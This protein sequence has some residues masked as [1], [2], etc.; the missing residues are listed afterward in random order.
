MQGFLYDNDE[1]NPADIEDIPVYDIGDNKVA[2]LLLPDIDAKVYIATRGVYHTQIEDALRGLGFKDIV[3]VTPELDI[4]LRNRYV[5]FC[6][7]ESGRVFNKLDADAGTS[8]MQEDVLLYIAKTAW[9]EGL[10]R[11]VTYP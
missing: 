3:R 7:E 10:Y 5:G 9:D 4:E 6:F 1:Q 11:L 2:S 8:D